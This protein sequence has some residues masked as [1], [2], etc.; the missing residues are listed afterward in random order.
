VIGFLKSLYLSKRV[1]Q[2]LF[3]I[4]L[5]FLA[6]YW[7]PTLYSIAWILVYLLSIALFIDTRM[8]YAKAGL[9][10]NRI[11]PEKFSN[12]DAN[13]IHL[14]LSNTYS[15]TT[16][17][18]IVDE[19]PFQFQ[20]RDFKLSTTLKPNQKKT[21]NYSVIP[22]ERGDYSFGYVHVYTSSPLRLIK[23]KISFNAKQNVKVYPS[24]LQMKKLEFMLLDNKAANIGF[25]KI[26]RIGQSKAFEQIK[27]YVQGD[28]VRTVNWK[29]TAKHGQLMVNQYQDERM[30]TVYTIIDSSRVMKL[31]F[32]G[33]SLLDYAINSSLAFSNIALKKGDKV[34]LVDFS[35]TLGKII[36]AQGKPSHLQKIL[37]SLYA[38]NTQ[39]LDADYSLL[40]TTIQR[41]IKQRSLLFL[42][43]NF[44]HI[45]SLKRQ[46]P[47]LRA[48]AKKHVLV[49]VFFENSLLKTISTSQGNTLQEVS[50]A[51]VAQQFEYDKKMIV[52]LLEKRG[53]QAILTKPESLSI[54]TIN[55]YLELKAKGLF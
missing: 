26:R 41:R 32:N 44:E 21:L 54:A 15:F 11:L 4:A 38:I 6:S 22:V 17:L 16:R 9:D 27:E 20:K 51:M 12:G 49:V 7:L 19:L 25:K 24:F 37:E 43:T 47:Y 5:F 45:S 1:V 2:F 35:N 18:E 13:L 29:A 33:L 28:D 53:I 39:F 46:L 50:Q 34:G 48:I 14:Y 3:C 10:G 40:Q 55:K 8:L 42:Y 31:P 30:Q 52:K 23:R 36:P